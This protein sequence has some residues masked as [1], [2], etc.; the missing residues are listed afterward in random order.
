[1]DMNNVH[2]QHGRWRAQPRDE[3]GSQISL[4]MYDTEA[5]A[6]AVIQNWTYRKMLELEARDDPESRDLAMLLAEKLG[7]VA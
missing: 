1:M 6:R 7:C 5:Q 4:G 3:A 2:F